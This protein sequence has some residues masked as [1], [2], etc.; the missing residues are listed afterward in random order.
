MTLVVD[1]LKLAPNLGQ[2]LDLSN[3]TVITTKVLCVQ[4]NFDALW[5]QVYVKSATDGLFCVNWPIVLRELFCY[6]VSFLTEKVSGI[7]SAK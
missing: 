4:Q 2:F 3:V 7:S 5:L 1:S 6:S